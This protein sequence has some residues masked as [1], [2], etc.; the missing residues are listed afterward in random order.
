MKNLSTSRNKAI[1]ILENI[2]EYMGDED[3]FDCKGG[4]STWYDLEDI[5][6]KIIERKEK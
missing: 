3:M 6:T 1:Q 5:I 4:E 2:A